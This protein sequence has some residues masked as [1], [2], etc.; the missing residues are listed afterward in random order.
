[1][2]KKKEVFEKEKK[3]K[4]DFDLFTEFYNANKNV[5]NENIFYFI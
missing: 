1:M 4:Y 5:S 3:K 2:S